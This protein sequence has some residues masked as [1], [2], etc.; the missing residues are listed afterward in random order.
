MEAGSFLIELLEK[1]QLTE[2]LLSPSS[3]MFDIT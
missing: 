2:S 1:L 3:S